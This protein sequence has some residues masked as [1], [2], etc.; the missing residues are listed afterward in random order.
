MQADALADERLSVALL[1][2]Q[3]RVASMALIHEFLY[4]SEYLDR[5]NFGRYVEQLANELQTSYT[6]NSGLIT[7][8]IEAEEIDLPVHRAIPCGLIVNELL[9]NAFKHGFPK[10]RSGKIIVR[11]AQLGSSMLSLSC[12]DN[13]V[14]IPGGIDWQNL[15]SLGLK[16][17]Q[18]LA[19]Q[20]DAELTLDASGGETCFEMT[21]ASVGQHLIEALPALASAVGTAESVPEPVTSAAPCQS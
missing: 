17:V 3:Q 15:R 12:R 16:I 7:V 9:S 14:G 4:G 2:S 19:K 5:V 20:I 10:K 8:A 11:F 13:G 18:I 21:F 1:E 6:G